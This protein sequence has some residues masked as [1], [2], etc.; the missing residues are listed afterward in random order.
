MRVRWGREGVGVVGDMG[1][2]KAYVSVRLAGLSCA[3]GADDVWD[4]VGEDG[5]TAAAGDGKG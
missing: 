2:V 1:V 4:G 5:E 3:H